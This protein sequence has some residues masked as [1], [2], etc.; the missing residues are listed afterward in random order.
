MKLAAYRK[1]QNLSRA[2][3]ALLIKT[4]VESVRR[5]ESGEHIPHRKIMARIQDATGGSVTAADFYA[6]QHESEAVA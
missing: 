5:Y 6:A 2:A 4:S 3:F 1:Q